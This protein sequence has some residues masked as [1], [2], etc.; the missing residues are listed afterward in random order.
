MSARPSSF[1]NRNSLEM[2]YKKLNLLALA[3]FTSVRV[4]AGTLPA[5]W[6]SFGCYTDNTS[7][8][9][10]KTAATSDVTNMTIEECIAFCTP[11]G[12][13]FAGL[14][15]GRECFCDFNIEATGVPAT[16]G[17]NMECTGDS[18][19]IC[20]GADRINI[21]KRIIPSGWSSVGCFTDQSPQRTL[22]T[23]A[24]SDVAGMTIEECA[25]FCTPLGFQFAGVEFGRECFCDNIIEST[26]APATD[27]CNMPCT[28]DSNEV[29]GGADR[30]NIYNHTALTHPIPVAPVPTNR[31]TVGTYQFQGCF[32]DLVNGSANA[33]SHHIVIPGGTTLELCTSYCK[34]AGFPVAGVELGHECWCDSYMPLVAQAPDSDCNLACQGPD[35]SQS[36]T[37]PPQNTCLTNVASLT[38]TT[39]S[40]RF[41]LQAVPVAGGTPSILGI[42]FLG[43]DQ[44]LPA[45]YPLIT[46]THFFPITE[47]FDTV[48]FNFLGNRFFPDA[49]GSDGIPFSQN[50][51]A[52]S[53]MSFIA[54]NNQAFPTFSQFCVMQTFGPFVGPPTLAVNGRNDQWFLC[55]GDNL[56]EGPTIFFQ[57]VPTA[58]V[59]CQNVF[60]SMTFPSIGSNCNGC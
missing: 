17:C 44:D 43:R 47:S 39:T 5:P 3:I 42:I 36:A 46:N 23:A 16:N 4:R 59:T 52:G 1:F 33:L 30:I 24:T 56:N 12:Y 28:G 41:N 38:S 11:T 50:V 53:E 13:T 37:P 34:A 31:Q 21:F 58:G 6:V 54:M 60:L 22:K 40:F 32:L 48:T 51:T 27:G 14:E 26:G 18:T 29:C 45:I 55:T 9:T 25:S 35:I 19:E 8:R 15:F 49:V 2:T 20:G 7:S 57:P 10:L